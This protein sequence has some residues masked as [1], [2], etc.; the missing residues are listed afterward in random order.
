M[1]RKVK[2]VADNGVSKTEIQIHHTEKNAYKTKVDTEVDRIKN[3]AFNFLR[4]R[5]YNFSE[6]KEQK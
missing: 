3:E 1:K 5:G 2:F 6:I 4:N